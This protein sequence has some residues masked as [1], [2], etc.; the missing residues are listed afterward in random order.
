VPNNDEVTSQALYLQ[1]CSGKE[2]EKKWFSAEVKRRE[3]K[4]QK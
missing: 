4:A 2:T 1:N 3:E